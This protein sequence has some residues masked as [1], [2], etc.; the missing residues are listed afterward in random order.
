MNNYNAQSTILD[1][2]CTHPANDLI[3]AV[4]FGFAT[5]A[6]EQLMLTHASTCD[7]CAEALAQAR[8]AAQVL[9]FVAP[10]AEPPASV[11]SGIESRIAD[12]PPASN[13]T[14]FTSKRVQAER[15]AFKLHW[16]VAA[17]LAVFTLTA[18]LLLGRMVFDT[19]SDPKKTEVAMVDVTD[20][21]TEATGSV[22]LLP[23]QDVILLNLQDMPVAP[24]GSVY[25]VWMITG[26]TPVSIGFFDPLSAKFAAV[27]DPANLGT[28][29]ITL[30]PAPLGSDLPSS[31]PIIVADLSKLKGE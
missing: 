11:W 8:F 2:Y 6:E 18:G 5:P 25:Q 4:A 16:A 15:G 17:L 31:D 28:L 20:P 19:G 1:R 7:I 14:A 30:E 10:D 26:D 3:E 13:V 9:P 27:A 24:E 22:Q 21:N 29:A 23:D 12:A